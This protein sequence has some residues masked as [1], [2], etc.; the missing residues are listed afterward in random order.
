MYRKTQLIIILILSFLTLSKAQDVKSSNLS[1]AKPM[2]FFSLNY[3]YQMS[4]IKDEDFVSSNYSPL[5]DAS[6]GKWFAPSLA[7]QIGYR[8][9]YFNCIS[10]EKKHY[11][12]YY[13]G[14]ALFNIK[15]LIKNYAKPPKWSFF[16][17]AG[18]GYFY[19]YDYDRPNICA[20]L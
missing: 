10:D 14:E 13:Y 12:G 15:A 16:L 3:G 19:N 4:G 6:L 2:W 20:H 5:L 11:Y 1:S 18:S 7:L 8:G 17:H 9:W